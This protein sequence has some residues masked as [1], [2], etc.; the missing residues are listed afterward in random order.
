M[1]L[2]AAGAEFVHGK[3][4]F[5]SGYLRYNKTDLA[6]LFCVYMSHEISHTQNAV[7]V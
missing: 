4:I 6:E 2:K 5:L 3:F 7:I 1:K